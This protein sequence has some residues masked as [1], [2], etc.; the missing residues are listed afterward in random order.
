[1]TISNNSFL[2]N[3]P[4]QKE[5]AIAKS[6]PKIGPPNDSRQKNHITCP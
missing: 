5:E 6:M 2:N 4:I 1:M 3:F